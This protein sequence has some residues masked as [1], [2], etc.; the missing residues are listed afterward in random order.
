MFRKA[1]ATMAIMAVTCSF[2]QGQETAQP[3]EKK[4]KF[5]WIKSLVGSINLTQTHFS[6]NWTQG[7]E[8]A[9]A[10]KGVIGTRWENNQPKTNWRNTAKLAYGQIKQG[11]E[12]VRKSDDE[13]R[14]ESV[15]TY[16]IGKYLNPYASFNGETQMTKGYKYTVVEGVTVQEP[17]SDFFS[18]AFLRESAG[19]GYKPGENFITRL[20]FS[21]K[22]TIVTKESISFNGQEYFLRPLYGNKLD[23]AVRVETGI[24]STTDFTQKLE[25]N[26]LFLSKLQLFTSFENFNTVDI[27]W[28]NTLTAKIS[29]LFAIN[30]FARVFYDED[31]L[32]EVQLKEDLG[33]GITYTFF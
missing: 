23:E 1:L 15:F 5:G 28:D 14:A 16:K 29:K 13:I 18:P 2:A 21:V 4:E 25:E 19:V 22:Q 30:V 17:V 20:G 24:E 10:W 31:V 7:G 26:V 9:L 8:N 27:T 11:D 33:F 32:P 6:S 12:G 3:E